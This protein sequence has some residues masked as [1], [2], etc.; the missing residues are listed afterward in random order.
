MVGFGRCDLPRPVEEP[1]LDDEK[2]EPVD[3]ASHQLAFDPVD[4]KLRRI[5]EV[6]DR[7][8]AKFGPHAVISG[9]LAA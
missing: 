4:E 7:A 3:Q 6:A 8:R 1:E 2:D 5:E 9:T